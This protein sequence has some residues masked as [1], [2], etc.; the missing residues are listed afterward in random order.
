MFEIHE[1]I[2]LGEDCF[3]TPVCMK[4]YMNSM[5]IYIYEGIHPSA[6]LVGGKKKKA[7]IVVRNDLLPTKPALG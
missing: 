1:K 4:C 7:H 3:L 2:K 6:G 5:M